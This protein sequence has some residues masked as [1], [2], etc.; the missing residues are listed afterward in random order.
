[1]INLNNRNDMI[2]SLLLLR[3]PKLRFLC[4]LLLA[5]VMSRPSG[6]S[7]AA[8]APPDDGNCGLFA[9][10]PIRM[11]ANCRPGELLRCGRPKD[12]T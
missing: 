11:I 3:L 10:G 8:A 12:I 2:R 9:S 1:M 5:L 6:Y 7:A 4:A